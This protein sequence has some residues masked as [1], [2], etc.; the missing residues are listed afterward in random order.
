MS[1]SAR[2]VVGILGSAGVL[3]FVAPKAFDS[4]V[5]SW[6]PG[7]PRTTT[8]VSGVCELTAAVLVAMPRTRRIG[9]WAALATFAAVWPANIWAALDGGM[10]DAAPPL[11]TATAAW[12]RV[13]FQ[14]PLFWLAWRVAHEPRRS[15]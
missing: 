4:L 2:A 3:H 9:G 12:V 1:G 8:L 7:S 15:R 14:L 13:P 6:T 11:D 5:P 10:H